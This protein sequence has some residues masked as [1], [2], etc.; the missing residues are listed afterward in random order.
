M[1]ACVTTGEKRG[2]ECKEV[3]TPSIAPGML[4]LKT[5]FACICGS[6][7][8][9]LDG[10]LTLIGRGVSHIGAVMGHSLAAGAESK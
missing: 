2:I 6:D 9:Y 10:S 5:K 7:L 4:L 1:R 3:P 8:E